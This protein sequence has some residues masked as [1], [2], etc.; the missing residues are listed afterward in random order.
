MYASLV[1]YVLNKAMAF[2]PLC[3]V[4]L[5]SKRILSKKTDQV[6]LSFFS[7]QYAV[8]LHTYVHT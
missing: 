8:S 3:H 5:I 7:Y 6:S 1:R 4:S 2:Y